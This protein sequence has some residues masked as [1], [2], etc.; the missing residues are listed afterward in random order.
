[1]GYCGV[2]VAGIRAQAPRVSA[3]DDPALATTLFG[4]QLTNPIGVAAGFDKNGRVYERM[5]AHG[6]GFVEIG[7]VTPMLL[8]E[9]LSLPT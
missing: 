8:L 1:M 2:S 4:R 5:G 3:D 9:L 6:F 7:G